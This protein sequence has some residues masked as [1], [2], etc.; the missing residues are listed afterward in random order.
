[1]EGT[2]PIAAGRTVTPRRPRLTRGLVVALAALAL[3]LLVVHPLGWIVFNSLHDDATGA[4]S[5]ANYATLVSNRSLIEPMVNS[6]LLGFAVAVLSVVLGV[7]I[8][9]L[10]ARTD[11][12]GRKLVGVLVL[13]AFVTPSFI[14]ATAWILLAAPNSGWLNVLARKLPGIGRPLFDIYSMPG[15]V[16]VSAIYTVPYTFTIVASVLEEIAVELEDAATTLG[17]R[18]LRTMWSISLP[19][20]MPSVIA[21]FILSF[22][23]G[24]TLFGVPA[25]L[26]VPAG[27][28]VVTTRLAEFYQ[29]F[30]PGLFASAAYCM[31]LLLVT[32]A[33]FSMR[34]RL[35]GRRQFVTIGG[36]A[37]AKRLIKLHRWRWPAF[38]AAMILPALAVVLPYVVLLLVS[39]SRSWGRGVSLDN[40]TW[41]WYWW[42]LFSSGDTVRAMRNS[43][44]YSAV[45][46]SACVILGTAVVYI[47]ERRL[48]WGGRILGALASAPIIIPGIVLSVGY[49][50]AY[51]HAPLNLYGTP[52]IMVTAFTATFL[53]IAYA[54]GGSI[55][56]GI[57]LELEHAARSLG[58]GEGRTFLSIT[59]PLMQAGLISGWLLV[60]IPIIREL[61]VVIFL[62]T[63]Q[64][65]VMTTLIYNAKDG[66][67]YE[68]L[69]AMSVLLLL[70]TLIVIVLV[71]RLSQCLLGRRLGGW[72][73]TALLEGVA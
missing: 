54:H 58:A 72:S 48:V 38:A 22:V 68:A 60:F 28:P 11:M 42:A 26:L 73:R 8:A 20:A 39:L 50:A 7:P 29:L 70:T 30:P 17:A 56:K 3:L 34:K 13:A 19:L 71:R 35:L 62:I 1:M 63:P 69:C 66:G 43:L 16:F 40:L 45:A 53:P 49:F 15:A 47:V 37:R 51:T 24:V 41:H 5:V 61:S 27:I 4:W 21:G 55:L 67:A 44:V 31:P 12:P 18:T 14:G 25:F 65:N 32:A 33:M 9:W 10:V 64:T 23:Q 46:A 59:A 6:L 52:A 36:K 57:G 2:G